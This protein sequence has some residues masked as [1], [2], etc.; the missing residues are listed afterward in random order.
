M[1]FDYLIIRVAQKLAKIKLIEVKPKKVPILA[2]FKI[3]SS[4]IRI[5]SRREI[6]C[7]CRFHLTKKLPLKLPL[8]R[9]L[10][11]KSYNDNLYIKT[12]F[13]SL[14]IANPY[15]QYLSRNTTFCD[16]FSKSN[17]LS[18]FQ[19]FQESNLKY[20]KYTYPELE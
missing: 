3:W 5:V 14:G 4:Y 7:I 17:L 16:Q 1:F 9:I 10:D 20:F 2:Y 15:F 19:L 18:A 8:M 13:S 12:K 6:W 11:Q